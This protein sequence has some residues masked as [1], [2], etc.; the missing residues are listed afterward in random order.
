MIR[1]ILSRPIAGDLGLLVLRVFTGALLIHH[2]YEKLANI[3]NFADAFVR[4]L[5]LPFPILLS[6][7]AAFSEVIGSWL[8]ITGL[9]TR[10]GALAVA[11]TISV[12]I[13]HAIVTAG[14]NIYLLELLG[15]YFAAAV[16]VLA[17]GPGVFSID[18]LIARR[19]EP[20]MQFSSEQ[21]GDLATSNG[22]VLEEVAVGR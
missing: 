15:L 21:D 9:L 4:P 19:L 12:A 5:H 18:E 8:L 11:G 22:S 14:F 3:E 2:G 13:Y 20:D 1:A 6:Y 17:C 10:M 7:V 16:A